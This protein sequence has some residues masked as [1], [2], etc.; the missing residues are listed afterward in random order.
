MQSRIWPSRPG[1]SRRPPGT[2]GNSG[3]CGL[4][5][6]RAAVH[7]CCAKA[8][9]SQTR[10]GLLALTDQD[11]PLIEDPRALC[12]RR[13]PGVQPPGLLPA[14]CWTLRTRT[15]PTGR[16]L[17]GQLSRPCSVADRGSLCTCRRPTGS[18]GARRRAPA[19]HRPLRRRLRP[20]SLR[21]GGLL[22]LRACRPWMCS[23]CGLDFTLP[24]RTG[25][26]TPLSPGGLSGSW[27]S[28]NSPAVFFSQELC[29]RY[30]TYTREGTDPLR[31]LRRRRHHPEKAAD[32]PPP[33]AISA[34]FFDVSRGAGP[35]GRSSVPRPAGAR[36]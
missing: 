31:P 34:A 13:G 5:H 9:C 16:P 35:A 7:A 10:G 15:A 25:E 11:A 27:W 30:F 18:G 22:P 24:A 2:A 23:G 26:G 3:P 29:A 1:S 21:R 19:L 28:G 32:R 20:A 14:S 8:F 6:R 17:P 4:P 12:R 33:W 36:R